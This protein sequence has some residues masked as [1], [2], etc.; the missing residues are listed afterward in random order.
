MTDQDLFS[1]DTA[2]LDEVER[3]Q[4]VRLADGAR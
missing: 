2:G 4:L 3:P 1:T